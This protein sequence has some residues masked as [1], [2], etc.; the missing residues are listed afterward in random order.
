MNCW[1]AYAL[2][3]RKK[4][5]QIHIHVYVYIGTRLYKFE[6]MKAVYVSHGR[7]Y[8]SFLLS[9]STKEAKLFTGNICAAA[10]PSA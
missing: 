4:M 2:E 9:I 3:V 5:S 1:Y 10:L 6:L 8:G 7:G